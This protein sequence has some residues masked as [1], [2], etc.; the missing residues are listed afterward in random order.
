M[1]AIQTTMVLP[2]VLHICHSAAVEKGR[3]WPRRT[4]DGHGGRIRNE[5]VLALHGQSYSTPLALP[6]GRN[7][8]SRGLAHNC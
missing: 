5:K 8:E 6:E 4:I 2:L 1:K 3:A 7:F